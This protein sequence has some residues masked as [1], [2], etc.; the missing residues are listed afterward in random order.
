[1]PA[2]QAT[3]GNATQ[4]AIEMLSPHEFAAL[5][6]L[7][8]SERHGELDPADIGTLVERQLVRLESRSAERNAIRITTDGERL[9]RSIGRG[10]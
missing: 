3:P 6:I 2:P 4:G 7:S 1:M 8:N 9:L 5:L 10:R